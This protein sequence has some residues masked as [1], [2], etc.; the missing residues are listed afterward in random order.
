MRDP[1]EA[2]ASLSGLS[3]QPEHSDWVL[4]T[5]SPPPCNHTLHVVSSSKQVPP[6]ILLVLWEF[7]NV[8]LSYSLFPQHLP[9]HLHFPTLMTFCALETCQV[10]KTARA[11]L[12]CGFPL[13]RRQFSLRLRLSFLVLP[14]HLWHLTIRGNCIGD[15]CLF[16]WFCFVL[17]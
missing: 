3:I 5:Q 15:F 12:V 1:G 11:L 13:E 9:I 10:Q 17:F 16:G 8:F 14:G 7:Y 6:L 4:V 2:G